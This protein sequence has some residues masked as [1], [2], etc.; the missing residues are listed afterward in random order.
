MCAHKIQR[1]TRIIMH[2]P[3][4]FSIYY[5][6]RIW[7]LLLSFV[8]TTIMFNKM[9][10]ADKFIDGWIGDLH[11]FSCTR[12]LRLSFLGGFRVRP[13][14]CRF[15]NLVSVS[16]LIITR[17][18]Q[19]ASVWVMQSRPPTLAIMCAQ[20]RDHWSLINNNNTV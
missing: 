17:F 6:L 16:R 10:S 15:A 3:R 13:W 8:C 2:W 14:W 11:L 4:V 9:N 19:L 5:L 7:K 20:H 1:Y 18:P 12:F